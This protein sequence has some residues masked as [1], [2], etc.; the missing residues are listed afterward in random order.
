MEARSSIPLSLTMRSLLLLCLASSGL[1]QVL[2]PSPH[3][4]SRSLQEIAQGDV[5][6]KQA[7][8]SAFSQAQLSGAWASIIGAAD[9]DW[10]RSEAC[11]PV[12]YPF[13]DP[14][15]GALF[16]VLSS[17]L[18][19]AAVIAPGNDI[20]SPT[21]GTLWLDAAAMDPS[22]AAFQ[23]YT[24]VAQ[25]LG[26]AYSRSFLQ[27]SF[28]P[29]PSLTQAMEA[30]YAGRVQLILGTTDSIDRY[31]GLH[32]SYSASLSHCTPWM[33]AAPLYVDGA[34]SLSTVDDLRAVL[35][36]AAAAGGAAAVSTA[37]G[38]GVLSS[39]AGSTL[40]G[41]L[42]ASAGGFSVRT[43][44]YSSP[45]AMMADLAVGVAI[46]AAFPG[47]H[48]WSNSSS[49]SSS[50][51]I[52][53]GQFKLLG[54]RSV[55]WMSMGSLFRMPLPAGMNSSFFIPSAT[56]Q[57]T[58]LLPSAALA[59]ASPAA[60]GDLQLKAALLAASN[61]IIQN[62]SWQTAWAPTGS[63]DFA[64]FD[65]CAGGDSSAFPFPPASSAVGAF[66]RLLSSGQLKAGYYYGTNLTA[67]N[68]AVLQ[69]TTPSGQVTGMGAVY[70]QMLAAVLSSQYGLP[71]SVSWTVSY[72]SSAASA[73]NNVYGL[74]LSGAVDVLAPTL[75]LGGDIPPANAAL[76]AGMLPSSQG[77]LYFPRMAVLDT[78]SCNSYATPTIMA[79]R[80]GESR[81]TSVKEL[82]AYLQG[83]Q[84]T[85]RVLQ[86][87]AQTPA[88]Q[89]VASSL[90]GPTANVSLVPDISLLYTAL[91]VTPPGFTA[92]LLDLVFRSSPP[93]SVQGMVAALPGSISFGVYGLFLRPAVSSSNDSIPLQTQPG[94]LEVA[95]C[96]AVNVPIGGGAF[97]P[98]SAGTGVLLTA[99]HGTVV[100]LAVAVAFLTLGMV[101][102]LGR[103]FL[104]R[105]VRKGSSQRG[106]AAGGTGAAGYSS[107][108]S[109]SSRSSIGETLPGSTAMEMTQ[110]PVGAGAAAAAPVTIDRNSAVLKAGGGGRVALNP[111]GTATFSN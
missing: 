111:I 2:L 72:S 10:V 91:V 51:P 1:S 76:P 71:I 49:S 26:M 40:Q 108:S 19:T 15:V 56:A 64:P 103:V 41:L 105:P 42:R 77:G 37:V 54:G 93:S 59:A 95:Q 23:W 67:Y 70:L 22:S 102:L 90:L 79:V 106:R 69:G 65:S 68:G 38:F 87:G 12:N 101:A 94:E 96:N 85:G 31:R 20:L 32:S 29:F 88:A 27:I 44:V 83:L 3:T 14:P 73:L 39:N 110:S 66:A 60:A 100:G 53:P 36:Q 9:P 52:Q 16:D 17:G 21:T 8:E 107:G 7:W 55:G 98:A 62:G 80:V 75:L 61:R 50:L 58:Q 25:Q 81:F 13:P 24:A 18:L 33:Q 86:V 92:P 5:Q 84:G 104:C 97:C 4:T 45:A 28:L 82:L 11:L 48:F 63:L 57:L 6:L 109:S 46:Q 99:G 35:S 30:L 43:V 34:S 89:L 74:L 78:L 47:V